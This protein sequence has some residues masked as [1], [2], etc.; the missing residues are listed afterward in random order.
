MIL[1]PNALDAMFNNSGKQTIIQSDKKMLEEAGFNVT[2][3]SLEDY[4]GNS[5]KLKKDFEQYKAFYAIGGNVFVLRKAMELSGFDK[6]LKEKSTRENVLYGGYSA[7]ICVLSRRLSVLKLADQ[8]RNPYNDD[9]VL[10]EGIGLID[11]LPIPHYKS[12]YPV[13][14]IIDRIVESCDRNGIRYKT[15]RDGESIVESTRDWER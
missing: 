5:N 12:G 9:E 6:F 2:V 15:L 8:P 13:G 11:F 4:F 3:A 10:E 14:D 1:I 7:G